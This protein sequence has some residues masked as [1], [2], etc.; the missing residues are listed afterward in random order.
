MFLPSQQELWL[1]INV[2]TR[3]GSVPVT[4]RRPVFPELSCIFGQFLVVVLFLPYKLFSH[5]E[6]TLYLLNTVA[7]P[8]QF[9]LT[10]HT[11][12]CKIETLSLGHIGHS[13]SS[14]GYSLG[15]FPGGPVAKTPISPMQGTRVQ[16]LVGELDL[17]GHNE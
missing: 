11:H 10:N 9:C 12:N 8:H 17:T 7:M 14:E 3:S 5:Q 2:F 6:W 15:N 1:A 13:H 4:Q 16:S